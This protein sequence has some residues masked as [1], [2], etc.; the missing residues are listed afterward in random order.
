MSRSKAVVIVNETFCNIYN[1]SKIDYSFPW[2]TKKESLNKIVLDKIVKF[3][4]QMLLNWKTNHLKH[5][6]IL[7]LSEVAFSYNEIEPRKSLPSNCGCSNAAQ[8]GPNWPLAQQP[9]RKRK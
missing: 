3:N 9:E 5:R 8:Q 2:S 4:Q 7:Y 6:F 1:L